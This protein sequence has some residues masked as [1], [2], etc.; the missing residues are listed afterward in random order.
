MADAASPKIAATIQ[1][2]CRGAT[3]STVSSL[4]GGFVEPDTIQA[5]LIEDVQHASTDCDV[6]A[7]LR[8]ARMDT[9]PIR[10]REHDLA[11]PHDRLHADT[12]VPRDP[13]DGALETLRTD[14]VDEPREGACRQGAPAAFTFAVA[15]VLV[16]RPPWN[17]PRVVR[18]RS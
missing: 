9:T 18:R 7:K 6:D 8:R 3:R 1:R 4:L 10:Q 14:V 11:V 5:Q 2:P 15:P 13:I 17:S 12:Q 16:P